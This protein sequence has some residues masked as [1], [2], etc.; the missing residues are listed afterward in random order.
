MQS[1]LYNLRHNI[2]LAYYNSLRF[3]IV[4][5]ASDIDLAPSLPMEL[6]WRLWMEIQQMLHHHTDL[7]SHWSIS[8][9]SN[10]YVQVPI[11]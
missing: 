5:T 6:F 11:L 1:V 4:F 3:I 2:R 9:H 10:M 7:A 8:L